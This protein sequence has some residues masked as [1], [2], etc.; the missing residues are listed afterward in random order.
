MHNNPLAKS[1]ALR[2]LY[3]LTDHIEQLPDDEL[4]PSF[5]SLLQETDRYEI[6]EPIATGG[7]KQIF[8]AYD[9]FTHRYVAMAQLSPDTARDRFDPFIHEAWVT[10]QLDHPNIIKIHDIGITPDHRPFFTMDLKSG[11]SL[12]HTIE[13]R[14]PQ[15]HLDVEDLDLFIRICDAVADAHSHGILHLDLKPSNIQFGHFGRM[16]VCDWG[17]ARPP[18]AEDGSSRVIDGWDIDHESTH[19]L[20]GQISGTPG[21]MAPEQIDL[22]DPKT[23]RTDIYALGCLL[24]FIL[25][26]KHPLSGTP[27]EMITQTCEGAFLKQL[28]KDHSVPAALQAIIAKATALEPSDRYGQVEQLISDIRKYQNG[29]SPSA[30]QTGFAAEALLLYRRNKKI[31]DLIFFCGLLLCLFSGLFINRLQKSRQQEHAAR[32]RALQTLA[33]YKEE[34]AALNQLSRTYSDEKYELGVQL[35]NEY[36]IVHPI[37]ACK[38]ALATLEAG[39]KIDPENQKIAMQLFYFHFLTLNFEAGRELRERYTEDISPV[40]DLVKIVEALP[41]INA[42]T[43]TTSDV[44][45]VIQAMKESEEA[46]ERKALVM[47]ILIFDHARRQDSA[48]YDDVIREVIHFNNPKWDKNSFSY[49]P[50]TKHLAIHGKALKQ[51]AVFRTGES[52]SILAYLPISHLDISHSGIYTLSHLYEIY[53]EELNISNTLISDL[54]EIN[55]LPGLRRLTISPNQFTEAQLATLPPKLEI[56]FSGE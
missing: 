10:A 37:K 43:P 25:T 14:K 55:K 39:L 23:E 31:C 27:Q 53:F 34:Q 44:I 16:V 42:E 46:A 29:Y 5:S 15:P 33:L 9:K 41:H 6:V 47:K 38:R 13:N 20:H 56:R 2:N 26:H 4:N 28:K 45:E 8:K 7:M 17:L 12:L 30:Q 50:K 18:H 22:K 51:L 19:S 11:D 40:M 48:N 21:Y 49:D 32:L 35:S 54:S 1:N 52:P 36:F 24:Y 3:D